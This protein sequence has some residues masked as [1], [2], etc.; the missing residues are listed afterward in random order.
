MHPA[1]LQPSELFVES[2]IRC[3][4]CRTI[5]AVSVSGNVPRTLFEHVTSDKYFSVVALRAVGLDL[6]RRLPHHPPL[7][8][9]VSPAE[10]Q[11]LA[12]HQL[13]VLGRLLGEDTTY[14]EVVPGGCALAFAVA[15]RVRIS[16]GVDVSAELTA[17]RFGCPRLGR[18][19]LQ[20]LADGATAS[21]RCARP[22]RQLEPR[23]QSGQRLR[24]RHIQP[25]HWSA[26]HLRRFRHGGEGCWPSSDGCC[27]SRR[28]GHKRG[29][30]SRQCVS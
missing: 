18:Y 22:A 10:T 1:P 4:S 7:T 5:Y 20:Q 30:G 9:N 19:R 28:N 24:L 16:I 25:T 2:L 8:R 21:G 3:L 17:P 12:C 14:L 6:F 23:S 15:R 27:V 13:N 11:E 29:C 26:R